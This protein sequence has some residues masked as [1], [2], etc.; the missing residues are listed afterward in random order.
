MSEKRRAMSLIREGLSKTTEG[1]VLAAETAV[2][3]VS[4][5]VLESTKETRK[6]NKCVKINGLN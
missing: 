5:A 6:S 2:G 4:A 3:D 1:V